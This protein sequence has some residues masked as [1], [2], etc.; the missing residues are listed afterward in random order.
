MLVSPPW[1]YAQGD[2]A[3]EAISLADSVLDLPEVASRDDWYSYE[4]SHSARPGRERLQVLDSIAF[5]YATQF[6]FDGYASAAARF[7]TLALS[8]GEVQ[9]LK[10][11]QIYEV[12]VEL[13]KT[14]DY[15]AAL[16]ALQRL[17][18]G[19]TLSSTQLVRVRLVQGFVLTDAGEI[20]D[21]VGAVNDAISL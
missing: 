16:A 8:L 3:E 9:A 13:A 19:S 18:E 11:L 20:A 10:T 1:V 12:L 5:M 2:L 7:E 14:N 17:S 4:A 6:K 15:A 21:A